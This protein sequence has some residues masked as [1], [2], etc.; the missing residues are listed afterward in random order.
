MNYA[1]IKYFDVS[2]GEGIRTSLYVSGCKN[3]CKGCFNQCA[4]DFLY[5]K[6]YTQEVEN[7]IL[8]SINKP[9]IQGL[10]IL[11]GDPMEIE[12]QPYVLGLIK[13]FREKYKNTKNIWIWS[14]YL[15]DKE[16]IE[17][18]KRFIPNITNEII[19][20]IDVLIDGLFILEKRDL[21]LKFR[22]SE[23]QRIIDV[24]KSLLNNKIILKENS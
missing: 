11:G 1:N 15:F 6:E 2:N 8:E 4:W 10:S 7:E 17:G 16:L 18:G 13:K 22:G 19:S 24:Q 9:F 20:N 12:N 14:G 21:M 3:H 23:N 5:G